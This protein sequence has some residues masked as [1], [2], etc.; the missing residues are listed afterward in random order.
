MANGTEDDCA[1]LPRHRMIV[2]TAGHI[3]H[4]K[5]A[6]VKA[7]TGVDAD[8]LP[9]EKARGVTL[10]LGF[11]YRTFPSGARIGFVDAPGHEK[12]V[13]TM[14][15][16]ATG[17]DF[18]LLVVAADDGIMPQTREHLAI[19][20]LLGI[21]RGAVALTK[22]DRVESARREAVRSEIEQAL[23][24]TSLRDATVVPCSSVTGEGIEA[25]GDLIEGAAVS[26][27]RPSAQGH[28]RMA[29]DRSFT[30]TGIGLVVTGTVHAGVARAG[31]ELFASPAGL[32]AR[33]RGLR[34]NDQPA[35]EAKV[36]DR[37]AL[38]LAGPRISRGAVARG[39]WIV[40]EGA[41]APTARFDAALTLLPGEDRPLRVWTPAHLHLGAQDVTARV[42]PLSA[43]SV[44]P[45][46]TALVQIVTDAETAALWGD[47]FVL[48]D[49]SARR[50]IGGGVVLDPFSPRRGARKP[51][52]LAALEAFGE[53]C[54]TSALAKLAGLGAEGV[55]LVAFARA[56]NLPPADA[57]RIEAE[58]EIVAADTG[59][60]RLGFSA[61]TWKALG[62]DVM[63]QL[64]DWQ[65]RNPES[66]GATV[67]EIVRRF[68]SPRRP[69][70]LAALRRLVEQGAI[71]R[72]GQL[73]HLPGHEIRLSAEDEIL[74]EEVRGAL[75]EAGADQ[76]RLERLAQRVSAEEPQLLALFSLL[77]R[78]GRVRRVGK[79][80][81][82]LPATLAQLA[83]EA[84][85]VAADHPDGLLTV[86]KFRDRTGVT[87]HMVMPLMEFFDRVGLTLRISDGRKLTRDWRE[88]FG[89]G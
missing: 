12:L 50:T 59:K 84:Q 62:A 23:K 28:F 26:S 30:L 51:Q 39:D 52:R 74:W 77:A 65:D 34:V 27:T 85:Q 55:D 36:G 58:A 29:V 16:G 37:C 9:E 11:A 41:H 46:E 88:I 3:D 75:L 61:Q 44:A 64:A 20:H 7:L 57:A 67:D 71:Q 18:A 43:R 69:G 87:R 81:Y 21:A 24:P 66:P 35:D 15:A 42:S 4:G 22:V 56:R 8:R 45:G 14:V 38:N 80:Y 40:A 72:F 49:Q 76:P 6:L 82:L 54:P 33:L 53:T 68:E 31:D 17:I 47:R 2:G 78:I 32:P 60:L 70:A 83:R 10:D 48:R 13:R 79:T 19:F 1:G 86:G 5:T 73:L 25:L 89:E 63:R